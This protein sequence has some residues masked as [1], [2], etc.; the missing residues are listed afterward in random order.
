MA[1]CKDKS[2][3]YLQKLGYNVVHH[4][5]EGVGPLHLIG[6][7][8]KT[9]ADLGTLEGML[10]EPVPP[11]PAAETDQ[12]A[13]DI[14]GQES[15]KLEMALGVNILGALI[16]AMGGT[17]GVNTKYTNARKISF[18]FESVLADRI[19]PIQIDRFL[20]EGEID[21][22]SPLIHEYI[23][24]NGELFVI[25]DV[26]KSKK[27]TVRY[28]ASDEVEARVDVPVVEELVGG[29]VQ[30]STSGEMQSVVSFTGSDPLVFGFRCLALG[31]LEGKV[32]LTLSKPG[33]IPLSVDKE[34]PE[35]GFAILSDGLL[36]LSPI[37]A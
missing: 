2:V 28:E 26:I 5:R 23:L 4:P 30:V 7:Q 25:T 34:V 1:L 32:R 36:Q 14:N 22:E 17:L 19:A 3:D 24:G 16:G 33:V 27:F 20:R 37:K 6:R 35:E 12:A 31:V 21:A 11:V 13:A 10:V 29:K 15:S 9:T 18:V 8:G